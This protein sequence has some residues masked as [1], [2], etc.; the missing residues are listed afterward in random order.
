MV[1]V[2]R[3]AG[4]DGWMISAGGDEWCIVGMGWPL[5]GRRVYVGWV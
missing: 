2:L 3:V 4:G 1:V 5:D